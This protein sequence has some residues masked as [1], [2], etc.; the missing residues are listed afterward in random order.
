MNTLVDTN[1]LLRL[2]EP[3]H[4][5]HQTALKALSVI[6]SRGDT[7]HVCSQNLIEF[8]AVASRP[9]TANG[10][11]MTT[12]Q[13]DAELSRILMLFPLLPDTSAIF[14]IWRQLVVGAGISGKPT[15]DA[16]LAA[17]AQV[18]GVD[19]LL[20]FNTGDFLRFSALVPT[21]QILDAA[22]I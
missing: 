6:G 14:G 12:A 2:A 1:L 3:A 19:C 5:M 17:V 8:W 16:R 10:L 9:V 11:G 13:A 4:P 7:V 15:H 18:H 20:T 22:T 21:L